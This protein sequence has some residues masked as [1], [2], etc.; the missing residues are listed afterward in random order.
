MRDRNASLLEG[1]FQE[2]D[3]SEDSLTGSLVGLGDRIIDGL[4]NFRLE[5][6]SKGSNLKR[7]SFEMGGKVVLLH[8]DGLSVRVLASRCRLLVR[9]Q[10]TNSEEGRK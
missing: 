4:L 10:D 9:F 1:V 6:G 8:C 3:S 5:G 7:L 2:V